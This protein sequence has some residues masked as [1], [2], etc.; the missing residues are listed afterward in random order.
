MENNMIRIEYVQELIG[1]KI[2]VVA[3]RDEWE[4]HLRLLEALASGALVIADKALAMPNGLHD[5]KSI[6]LYDSALSLKEAIMYYL[7][8]KNDKE[9]LSIA[10]RGWE[11]AMGRHRSWHRVEEIIFGK[12]LTQVDRPFDLA[13][14]K[15]KRRIKQEQEAEFVRLYGDGVRES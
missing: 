13:P 9:R 1:T 5:R 14:A 7:N 6:V 4:G 10:R 2:V 12:P 15:R 8:P 11:T 3:Q